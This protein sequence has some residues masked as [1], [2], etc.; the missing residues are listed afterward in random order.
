MYCKASGIQDSYDEIVSVELLDEVE[1]YDLE[2]DHPTHAFYA[3]DFVVSNSHSTAYAIDSYYA[4]WL[5]THYETYWLAT[6]LQS[7]N[8]NPDGLKKAITEIKAYGYQFQEA[9]INYSG[10]VWNYSEELEAFVPPLSQPLSDLP[11]SHQTICPHTPP[12]SHQTSHALPKNPSE[13]TLGSAAPD[14]PECLKSVSALFL[15]SSGK[16]PRPSSLKPLRPS[17]Y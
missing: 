1:T 14:P 6:I 4:A 5:H 3:N 12:P 17:S 11:T 8:G 2:V 9:D 16:I 10:D 15:R 13:Q 7:E